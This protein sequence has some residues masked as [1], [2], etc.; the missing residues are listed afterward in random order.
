MLA[1]GLLRSFAPVLALAL[2][3]PAALAR[4]VSLYATVEKDGALIGGLTEENFHLYEGGELRP[5]R[6]APPEEKAAIAL[7]V[8]YSRGS[9]IYFNDILAA[10]EGFHRRAPEG[11]W[12]ALA[13]FSHTLEIPVDFT[14]LRGNILNAFRGLPYPAWREVNTYDAVYE[15]LDKMDRLSGR[16]VLIVIGSGLDTFSARPLNEVKRIAERANVTIYCVGAGSLLRG[17]YE[18]SLTTMAR[19]E[20]TQAEAFFRMLAQKTGGEAWFPRF[21]AAFL[22]V[23]EGIMQT[24]AHQ[25]RIVYDSQIPDD[26]EFH[27]IELEAFQVIEDK[28]EDFKVRVREGWRG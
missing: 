13:T 17:R 22:N 11:H 18:A 24:L 5:F 15:M 6:L 2:L 1:S 14:R 4:E 3:A 16:R 10:I 8:E 9:W 28:R 25:Y 7:L 12:Y 19:M 23:M 21:E 27:R 20:L 26:G